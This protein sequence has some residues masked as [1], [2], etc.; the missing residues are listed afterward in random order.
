[1]ESKKEQWT[2]VKHFKPLDEETL[3]KIKNYNWCRSVNKNFKGL[4]SQRKDKTEFIPC[5][6]KTFGLDTEDIP[7]DNI[8]SFKDISLKQLGEYLDLHHKKKINLAKYWKV[9]DIHFGETKFGT[10]IKYTIVGFGE[11]DIAKRLCKE[12][13]ETLI[14]VRYDTSTECGYFCI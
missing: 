12:V 13:L 3:N 14:T 10:P 5:G 2:V 6:P 4:Y 9:G 1:M 8:K 7:K 11:T